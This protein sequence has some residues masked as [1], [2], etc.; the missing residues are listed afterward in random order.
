MQGNAIDRRVESRR[1]ISVRRG[2]YRIGPIAQPFEPEMAAILPLGDRAVLS[3]D[4]AVFIYQLL[5]HPARPADVH[6]TVRGPDPGPKRGIK[7]HRTSQ[8]PPDETTRR[9]RL[10]I[11]T[12]ARTILDIAPTLTEQPLEQVIAQAH[13]KNLATPA[14]LDTSLPATPGGRAPRP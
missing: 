6:I 8:L 11:T 1:L 10:P 9:H 3:H 4:T 5:P 13:R 14:Q 12:P 7:I 2:I